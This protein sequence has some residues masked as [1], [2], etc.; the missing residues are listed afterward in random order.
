MRFQAFFSASAYGGRIMNNTGQIYSLWYVK[1]ARLET[2][3]L[4]NNCGQNWTLGVMY[5]LNLS[6]FTA[7]AAVK[8]LRH[9]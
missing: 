4:D 5:K 2:T 9:K 6:E 7:V 3:K 1:R 8:S